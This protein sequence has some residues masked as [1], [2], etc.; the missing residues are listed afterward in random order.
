M[1]Q[2]KVPKINQV[3]GNTTV[4]PCHGGG[5]LNIA[6]TA[7]IR[8]HFIHI[9]VGRI[10]EKTNVIAAKVSLCTTVTVVAAAD[11]VFGS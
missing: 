2:V 3:P 4:T 6:S 7:D 9:S 5:K 8:D 10:P 1:L 11:D